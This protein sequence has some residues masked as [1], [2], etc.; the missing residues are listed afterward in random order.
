MYVV[1]DCL[2]RAVSAHY[3]LASSRSVS[4]GLVRLVRRESLVAHFDLLF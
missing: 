3:S 4:T 2:P 1:I